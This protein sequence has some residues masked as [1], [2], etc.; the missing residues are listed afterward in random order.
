MNYVLF[1]GSKVG[2]EALRL[3]IDLNCSIRHVFVESEH[4]HEHEKYFGKSVEVCEL[5]HIQ[6]SLDASSREI[7]KLLT[8]EVSRGNGTDYIMSFGYRK[9]IDKAV[10]ELPKVAALG[11]HFSPLP[12]Y[13]G[14]APLNW[15]LI[16]GETET[17]V[18]LFCLETEVDAGDIVDREWVEIDYTDDINSLFEKCIVAFRRLMRR[19]IPTLEGGKFELTKQDSVRATYTC[20]RSP[21]DGLIDWNWSS[22]KIYNFVRAQTYPY[23]GA[24][25]YMGDEKLTVWSCSEY[26]IPRY[27]GRI[28]GKVIGVVQ[29]KGAVILCGEGA[30]LLNE[31]QIEDGARDTAD[32]IIRSIRLT[33]GLRDR[34]YGT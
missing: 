10:L 2:F 19:A 5:H 16:N 34:L 1:I 4:S 8:C 14:F 21:K 28:P 20:A 31:V 26:P 11:T 7:H 30:V 32:R 24:Y 18:N 25:T 29:N 12:R 9:M 6:Y 17:A 33:L 23:P 3:M 13:R 15:V 22:A 27:E